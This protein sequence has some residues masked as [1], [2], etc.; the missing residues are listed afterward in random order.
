MRAALPCGPAG[1]P[2]RQE[3]PTRLPQNR[4][5]GLC[6]TSP[7][8]SV[9]AGRTRARA[10]WSGCANVLV[11]RRAISKEPSV[12]TGLSGVSL[13]GEPDA[14]M[15]GWFPGETGGKSGTAVAMGDWADHHGGLLRSR[16]PRDGL[17]AMRWSVRMIQTEGGGR[18]APVL[19]H[20]TTEGRPEREPATLHFWAARPPG[21][22]DSHE[23]K[24]CRAPEGSPG[25]GPRTSG[26]R[27]PGESQ[28]TENTCFSKQPERQ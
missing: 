3:W 21:H 1:G 5:H 11:C 8:C 27:G 12:D 10:V 15:Q 19:P 6:V 4:A 20:P 25:M 7:V 26:T 18:L 17:R 28:I 24:V 22:W 9:F 14:G 16:W 23:A 13:N 2:R